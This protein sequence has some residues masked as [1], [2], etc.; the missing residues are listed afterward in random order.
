MSQRL[1]REVI[2]RRRVKDDIDD[3]PG[4]DSFLDIVANIVGILVLLVV[5]VGVRAAGSVEMP[6]TSTQID[7]EA[8]ASEEKKAVRD[9]LASQQDVARL[10]KQISIAKEESWMKD[11][12]RLTLAGLAKQLRSDLD[13]ERAKLDEQDKAAYDQNNRLAQAHLELEKLAQEEL[14]LMA[15]EAP[16]QETIEFDSTPI[17]RERVKD[18]VFLRIVNDQVAYLPITELKQEFERNLNSVRN[19]LASQPGDYATI[20]RVVGPIEG[21]TLRCIFQ[22]QIVNTPQGASIIGGLAIARLEEYGSHHSEP[23]DSAATEGG[24][25]HQRLAAI[26]P[27]KTVVTLAIYPD[28]FDVV[29]EFEQALRKQ[30]FRVAKSLL[31]EGARIT[32]SPNGRETMLQ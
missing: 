6:E 14:S 28:S 2:M 9:A 13:A 24:Y 12:A 7:R 27:K 23:I 20:E 29:P 10:T 32:F 5:V 26:D 1:A 18:E 22:R 8:I 21:F 16:E 11:Q 4:G 25:I 3:T 15:I 30:G 31:R 17:I 19:A